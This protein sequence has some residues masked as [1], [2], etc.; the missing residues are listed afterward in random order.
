MACKTTFY[1]ELS[2][3]PPSTFLLDNELVIMIKKNTSFLI[4]N[5]CHFKTDFKFTGT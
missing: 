2:L 5:D 4:P 1:F 3:R